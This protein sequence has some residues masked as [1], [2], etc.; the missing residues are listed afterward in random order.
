[1]ESQFIQTNA[2]SV[3]A[4]H[5]KP[6]KKFT[7]CGTQ[8]L[9]SEAGDALLLQD[10]NYSCVP[11]WNPLPL[12]PKPE[13]LC[14]QPFSLALI[15]DSSYQPLWLL[16]LLIN[17]EEDTDIT[18]ANDMNDHSQVSF[19]DNDV[20]NSSIQVRCDEEVRDN[21]SFNISFEE[22]DQGTTQSNFLS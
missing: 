10:H 9:A 12:F 16:E 13:S 17:L 21:S 6:E 11:P 3:K 8:W 4:E 18:I 22:V 1:M 5:C 15:K 14:T 2:K 20:D 7:T 19:D